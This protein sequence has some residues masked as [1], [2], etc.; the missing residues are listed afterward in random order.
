VVKTVV[1]GVNLRHITERG[2]LGVVNDT[3]YVRCYWPVFDQPT[4]LFAAGSSGIEV[5]GPP[6]PRNIVFPIGTVFLPVVVNDAPLNEPPR[7]RETDVMTKADCF[8]LRGVEV[9]Q[10]DEKEVATKSVE[11]EP[12]ITV[13]VSYEKPVRRQRD[14][15]V[16]T[17]VNVDTARRIAAGEVE[18]DDVKVELVRV[19]R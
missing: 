5:Q 19:R 12:G 7:W 17:H 3:R 9:Q 15:E 16:I 4:E 6:S 13:E 14:V 1:T 10:V 11:V 18:A 2:G 8:F